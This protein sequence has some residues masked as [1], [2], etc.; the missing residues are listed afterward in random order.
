MHLLILK[1]LKRSVLNVLINF[2]VF[3]KISFRSLEKWR[4]A[5]WKHVIIQNILTES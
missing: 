5:V 3:E 1:C 4:D 2:K